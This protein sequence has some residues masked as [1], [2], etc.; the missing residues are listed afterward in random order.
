MRRRS[1]PRRLIPMVDRQADADTEMVM[2]PRH[3]TKKMIDAAWAEAL[4]E[5]AAGVWRV[6]VETWLTEHRKVY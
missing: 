1:H 3:P 2:V 6:M 5:D 4:A